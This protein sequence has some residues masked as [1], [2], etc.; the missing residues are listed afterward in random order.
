MEDGNVKLVATRAITIIGELEWRD[1]CV[2]E[3]QE[4]IG[5]AILRVIYLN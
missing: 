4:F 1:G 5:K 2:A 3:F